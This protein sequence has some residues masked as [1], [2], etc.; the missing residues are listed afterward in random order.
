MEQTLARVPALEKAGIKQMINGPESCADGN[1][2]WARRRAEELTCRR[3]LQR[4]ASPRAGRRPRARRVEAEGEAPMD[5]WP[6]D[7]RRFG[8]VHRDRNWVITR[9]LEAY[10]HHCSMAAAR[11]SW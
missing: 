8:Q 11:G 3:R 4:S 7:I 9:T 6:V 1:F 10:A 5:L 2:I